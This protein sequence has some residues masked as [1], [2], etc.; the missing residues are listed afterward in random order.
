MI[1]LGQPELR[2]KV[3]LPE[4]RQ[5]RQRIAVQ[6]HLEPLSRQETKD[7]IAHRLRIA[8]PARELHFKKSAMGEVYLYSGGVPRLINTLCDQALLAAYTA[9]AR[10][11]RRGW[12]RR[13]PG[14]WNGA[15]GGI[16]GFVFQVLVRGVRSAA[17]TP[18]APR[19]NWSNRFTNLAAKE[20]RYLMTREATDEVK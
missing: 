5:L 2:Q 8:N 18:A 19:P 4:L 1:L 11:R 13:S 14:I 10:E 6:Y 17:G 20:I 16:G 3:R 15:V 7:Y 12:A 9:E